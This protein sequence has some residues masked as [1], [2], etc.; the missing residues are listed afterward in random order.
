MK[1][2]II[3]VGNRQVGWRCRDGIVRSFGADGSHKTPPHL[4]ELDREF[5]VAR[6]FHD[7]EGNYRHSV[8]YYSVCYLSE[9]VYQ[10]CHAKSDFSPVVLLLDEQILAKHYATP[11]ETADV[12]LWGTDQPET[13]SW[14]FRSIDTCWLGELMAG[15]I[16][17]CYPHLNVMVWNCR[18][19]LNHRQHL[20]DLTEK[21]LEQ[22]IESLPDKAAGNWQLQI[23]TK[24][25]VPQIA[26][27]L[28]L[29]SSPR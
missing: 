5:G 15:V 21:Q 24:G 9:I 29:T 22:Y 8:R 12:I 26:D 1:T 3:T 25:S 28:N 10:H 4:D 2:L 18:V 17:Q 14:Q 27:A 11:T 19:D 23:Q 7:P 20:W 6:G 16:R 13:V